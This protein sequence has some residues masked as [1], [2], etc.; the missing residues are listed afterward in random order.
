MLFAQLDP[1][2]PSPFLHPCPLHLAR[3]LISHG[4]QSMLL[5][6]HRGNITDGIPFINLKL[7]D[8]YLLH[9]FV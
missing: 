1:Q 7:W 9:P 5:G 2:F 8:Y 4:P 3:V 6:Y